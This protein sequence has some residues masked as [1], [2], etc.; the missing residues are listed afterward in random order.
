[1]NLRNIICVYEQDLDISNYV[2]E[3]FPEI[4]WDGKLLMNIML[5][6]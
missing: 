2:Y 3:G 4:K 5:I 6:Y 1:M